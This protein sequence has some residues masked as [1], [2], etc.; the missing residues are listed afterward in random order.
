M[1]VGYQAL[2]NNNGNDNT[3]IGYQA[4]YYNTSGEGNLALGTGAGL[5]NQEG[6]NNVLIGVDAGLGS[7]LHNK[8]NNVMIGFGAGAINE[9][10]GNVFLGYNA[11]A[12]S[13]GSNEL[14]IDNS[15]T[16]SPL[17]YGKFDANQ[18]VINGNDGNNSGNYTLFV[19][20]TI[21][22]NSATSSH[23]DRRLKSN[24][25]TVSSALSKVTELRGVT[26]EWI[27]GREKGR[28]LGFVAQ[29]VEKIL[30]EVVNSSNDYYTMQ[31]AP[32]TALLVEA[33]K[34]QQLLIDQMQKTIADLK[35]QN[36]KMDK[37]EAMLIEMKGLL[38]YQVESNA[39]DK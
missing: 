26:F 33:V 14:F 31:Y 1:G 20:G 4:L 16:S 22:S 34:E 3:A 2:Y 10:L 27:D 17:I 15:N 35:D 21:G 39:A 32:I 36:Q 25:Q 37:L 28:R 19:N 24:I 18:V 11:G 13:S 23:S 38:Q 30:P 7:S 9:G 29:E 5:N 8:S 6:N 12:N